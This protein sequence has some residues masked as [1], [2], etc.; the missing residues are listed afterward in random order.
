MYFNVLNSADM[1]LY[2]QF[3][4]D[5]CMGSC[6][7]IDNVDD[8]FLS[9]APREVKPL[10]IRG[11]PS[12]IDVLAKRI[13]SIP[14][15]VGCLEKSWIQHKLNA[16]GSAI[17]SKVS[18]RGT[19][20]KEHLVELPMKGSTY[21]LPFFTLEALKAADQLQAFLG[22]TDVQ[23]RRLTGFVETHQVY[24]DGWMI[25]RLDND[26][27]IYRI[28]MYGRRLSLAKELSSKQP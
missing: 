25:L 21:Q 16:P 4:Q 19:I 24:M 26:Q 15:I 9:Q 1:S 2:R 22:E 10:T 20:L 18:F 6:S 28:E 14:D 23:T 17:I 7:M 8:S 27:R 11:L 3:F 5:F 12:V 13:G